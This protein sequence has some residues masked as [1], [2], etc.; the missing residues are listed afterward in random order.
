[1]SRQ[2]GREPLWER[3]LS[4]LRAHP[5]HSAALAGRLQEP[6][7]TISTRLGELRRAGLVVRLPD[8]R[9]ARTVTWTYEWDAS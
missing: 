9:W 4:S 2:L 6:P 7:R 1:L 3:I 8:G 5:L